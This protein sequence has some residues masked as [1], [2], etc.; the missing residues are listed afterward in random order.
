MIGTSYSW[1]WS[2]GVLFAT[3]MVP[4]GLG[5]YV[6]SAVIFVSSV[7]CAA[8]AWRCWKDESA[9][10]ALARTIRRVK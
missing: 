9:N 5:E 4:A 1:T 7:A 3:A 10:P 2:S 6:A 8:L